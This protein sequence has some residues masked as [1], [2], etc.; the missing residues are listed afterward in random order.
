M[1]L[2]RREALILRTVSWVAF[3][4]VL[5]IIP[6]FLVH[7]LEPNQILVVANLNV[8]GGLRV[9]KDYMEKRAIPDGNLLA[10][11]LTDKETCSREE[12]NQKVAMPVRK[13]LRV[14]DPEGRIRC[15]VT[16]YD[17]PLKVSPPEMSDSERGQLDELRTKERTLMNL[18]DGRRGG[19][20]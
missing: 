17:M 2:G 14:K 16:I 1:H 6:C 18:R 4:A 12:Y 15:L 19:G 8:A 20:D 3:C 9:A 13:Y 10:L 7:A 5:V 11:R